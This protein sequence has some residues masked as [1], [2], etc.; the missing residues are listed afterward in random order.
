MSSL[1]FDP[2]A[3]LYDV[4]RGHPDDIAQ[5]IGQTIAKIANAT[6]QTDFLEIGIGTGR[7]AL[8]LAVLGHTY[9]GVDISQKMLQMLEAKLQTQAWQ[10]QEQPWG[11]LPDEDPTRVSAV[12]RFRQGEGS[13][14]MRL[15]ISDMTTLPFLDASFDVVIA[16]HVFHLVADWLQ[17]VREVRRVL[18]PG[19]VFLHCWDEFV[20]S[21][22]QRVDDEWLRILHELGGKINRPGAA[23][24]SSV[25]ELLQSWGLQPQ[26]FFVAKW[27][28]SVTPRQAVEYLAQRLWSGTWGVPDD[29][30]A[31]SI[32]LL[33]HWATSYY[34]EKMDTEQKQER[35]FVISRTQ[36][37]Q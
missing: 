17:A 3:H 8:P 26:E 22:I 37:E 30:F 24:C 29:L 1:S 32:E 16:V 5:Q 18:R 31:T 14:S 12:Q 4:T 15:V 35:R 36:I 33:R 10:E 7:I 34:G 13:A 20:V 6:A 25:A 19:G 11:T 2:I 28:S 9:T 27:E 23:S 21:D